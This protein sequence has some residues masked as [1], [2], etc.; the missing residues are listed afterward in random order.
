M[1][2]KWIQKRLS[3]WFGTNVIVFLFLFCFIQFYLES[4]FRRQQQQQQKRKE[5]EED[6]DTFTFTRD[7]KNPIFQSTKVI[8]F[9][10][11]HT[12]VLTHYRTEQI[13]CRLSIII[14]I[15]NIDHLFSFFPNSIFQLNADV[16]YNDKE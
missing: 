16:R 7:T 6:F 4:I 13:C 11:I 8:I 3:Y 12:N 1:C 2:E 15:I 9:K 5:T 14:V 10:S